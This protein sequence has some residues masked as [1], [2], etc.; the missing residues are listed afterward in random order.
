[1]K[2]FGGNRGRLV[3]QRSRNSI[4]L[5]E[6]LAD[7][8]ERERKLEAQRKAA[9]EK[10]AEEKEAEEKR[11]WNMRYENMKE[12]K[13]NYVDQVEN[14]IRRMENEIGDRMTLPEDWQVLPTTHEGRPVRMPGSKK[15]THVS[16]LSA[17][18]AV[19]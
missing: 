13:R 4:A 1:M 8:E 16:K 11:L 6:E 14:E 17:E 18:D 7:A 5:D 3:R 15:E 2:K 10:E 12:S 9:E 19:R